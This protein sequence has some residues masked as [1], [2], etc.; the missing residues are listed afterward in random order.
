MNDQLPEWAII[1]G[2][3]GFPIVLAIYLLFR[4]EKKIENLSNAIDQLRE[5]IIS[6]KK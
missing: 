2:N 1:V 3:Y 5:S 4:F 6:K